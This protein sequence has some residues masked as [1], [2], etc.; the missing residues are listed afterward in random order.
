MTALRLF[1]LFVAINFF[2]QAQVVETDSVDRRVPLDVLVQEQQDSSLFDVDYSVKKYIS[3]LKS[4][5][6]Q[7][8]S[9]KPFSD[10]SLL[11]KVKLLSRIKPEG[12][13]LIG[14][15]HGLLLG[16][17]D[18]SNVNPISVLRSEGDLGLNAMGLPLRFSYNYSSFRNPLGVNNFMRFSLDT[19]KIRKIVF[20]I[21]Y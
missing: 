7:K 20:K 14:F 6:N 9:I 18:T 15:D 3:S 5:Q 4:I 8:N 17:I 19:E 16:Y 1:I 11:E 21:L 2:T 13:L 10:S 12:N